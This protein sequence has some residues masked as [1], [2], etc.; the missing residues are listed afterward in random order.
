[1][2]G[3]PPSVPTEVPPKPAQPQP[4]PEPV[5][6]PP[7]AQQQPA[8]APGRGIILNGLHINPVQLQQLLASVGQVWQLYIEF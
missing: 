8:Q 5:L 4:E 1:M 3:Q 7:P 2:P 6:P